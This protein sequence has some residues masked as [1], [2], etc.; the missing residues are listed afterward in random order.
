MELAPLLL[1]VLLAVA[2]FAALGWGTSRHRRS[3]RLWRETADGLGLSFQPPGWIAGR[4]PLQRIAGTLEGLEVEAVVR[5]ALGHG[6]S[7]I[8]V[9]A[10]GAVGHASETITFGPGGAC[11]RPEAAQ[12]LLVPEL[13]A[14]LL[15]IAGRD[16]VVLVVDAE[17]VALGWVMPLSG[18][19]N[20]ERV[21]KSLRFV[22]SLAKRLAAAQA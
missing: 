18:D 22:V 1:I 6:P 13:H 11:D 12:R 14:A 19:E 15:E 2:V 17:T 7:S 16:A 3:L 10:R 5:T 20:P 21:A 8:E 9:A 4:E